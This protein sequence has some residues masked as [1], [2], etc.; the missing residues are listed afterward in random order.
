MWRVGSDV[1]QP[2]AIL[3]ERRHPGYAGPDKTKATGHAGRLRSF[4][5]VF[6]PPSSKRPYGGQWTP[7]EGLMLSMK[8]EALGID[9]N[10]PSRLTVRIDHFA[11]VMPPHIRVLA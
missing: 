8:I 10:L 3:S 11:G 1:R 7:H 9:R 6:T 2:T 4:R 5:V